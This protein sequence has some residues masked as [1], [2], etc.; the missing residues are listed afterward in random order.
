MI[1]VLLGFTLFL[2]ATALPLA[3]SSQPVEV[4][5]LGPQVGE[6]V[7]DFSAVDQNGR[8]QTLQSVLGPNGAMVVFTRS[9]D[10]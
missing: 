8:T 1:R 5:R 4:D 9:V 10:W 7:P 6:V 3:Q 2:F